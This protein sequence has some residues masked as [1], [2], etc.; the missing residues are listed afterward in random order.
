MR[1]GIRVTRSRLKC[2]IH[3]LDPQPVHIARLDV[4]ISVAHPN[5]VCHLDSNHKLIRR[6]LIIHVMV[7]REKYSYLYCANNRKACTVVQQFS[8]AVTEYS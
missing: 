7:S 2:S 6:R 5:S 1:Q 3:R 8:Q 4:G